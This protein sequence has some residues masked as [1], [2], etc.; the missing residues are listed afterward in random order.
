M[1]ARVLGL[2]KW[3]SALYVSENILKWEYSFGYNVKSQPSVATNVLGETCGGSLS[4]FT[5][6]SQTDYLT[7][8]SLLS[9]K[10]NPSPTESSH[11]HLL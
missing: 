1:L 3:H 6:G 7:H 10:S 11:I 2:V 5:F 4:Y 9:L 8:Q